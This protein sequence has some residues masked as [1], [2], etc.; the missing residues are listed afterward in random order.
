MDWRSESEL[1]EL[2]EQR[3]GELFQEGSQGDSLSTLTAMV[4]L[5][6]LEN[7]LEFVR[8]AQAPPQEPDAP[9]RVPIDRKPN[10]SGAIALP[11]PES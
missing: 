6:D 9:V 8:S 2:I 3:K 10:L 7:E 1:V 5:A 11:E 4:E